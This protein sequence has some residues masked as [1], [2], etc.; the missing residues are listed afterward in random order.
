[1]VKIDIISGF[2]GAGKTTFVNLLLKHYISE[3][4]RPVCIVNEFGEIGLDSKIIN[5]N[6]FTAVEIEGGCIC[7]TLKD[8]IAKTIVEVIE[9][10]NPTNI[11]FEPSGIFIFD[12]FYDIINS[13][14]L[15]GKCE[16]SNAIT[17]VD[18]LNFNFSKI[19]YGSFI[20]NQ[21][22]NTTKIVISKLEKEQNEIEE[23][24]CDINNI[25]S[26]TTI[27][28]KKWDLWEKQ[29]F[30]LLLSKSDTPIQ[31]H[32]THKHKKI[33][34]FTINS[35][36]NLTP[37]QFDT[38]IDLNANYFFGDIFRIK[39]IINIDGKQ[40]LLNIALENVCLEDFKGI[41]KTTLTFIGENIDNMKIKGFFDGCEN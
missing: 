3:G 15:K 38:L 22:R 2:L 35:K 40:K 21:I 37:K 26:E 41:A 4:L 28:S 16:L 27:F 14:E 19:K 11:V 10:L 31:G 34:T 32:P 25:N 17:I 9:K 7:C 6:G 24:F 8:D 12:N 29:D 39:G 20:Y 30:D 13:D 5:A 36:L 1:M 23:L 18:S 33:K